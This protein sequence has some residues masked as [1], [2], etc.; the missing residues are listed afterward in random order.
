MAFFVIKTF[1]AAALYHTSGLAALF[2]ALAF[3]AAVKHGNT[4][5]S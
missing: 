3:F 5:P 2:V 1:L 4:P